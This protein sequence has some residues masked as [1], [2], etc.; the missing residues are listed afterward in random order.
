M[1]ESEHQSGRRRRE[2]VERDPLR[3]APRTHTPRG[4]LRIAADLGVLPRGDTLNADCKPWGYP[5]K[6]MQ[7]PVVFAFMVT[8]VAGL[9]TGIGSALAFFTKQTNRQ[10]LSL[11]L[12]FSAGVMIYVSF[13][14]ILPKS[15]ERLV[16]EHGEFSGLSYAVIAFLAGLLLMAVIDRVIPKFSNPHENISIELMEDPNARD[17]YLRQRA[18]M[19]TG[20]FV[21]IA[22]ALHNFPEG[23]ATF[24]ITLQEPAVGV[25]VALAIAIHNIPEGIA[26]SV[27]VY[28]ATGKKGKAFRYSFLSG[29]AEPMGALLGYFALRPFLTDSAL[30]VIFAA[31]AGIMVFISLDELLPAARE[32][33]KPHLAIYG[34]I[35]GMAVMAASLLLFTL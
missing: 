9:A 30:G 6:P 31:V 3:G 22:V 21:A 17:E 8:L 11:A 4:V 29:I 2:I 1:R 7:D 24:L 28:Y 5:Q 25:A 26:I 19:K 12:G 32:Y 18:L 35:A 14:E 34:L 23:L 16:A 33:G 13:V 27:P 15:S 20:T 10:F